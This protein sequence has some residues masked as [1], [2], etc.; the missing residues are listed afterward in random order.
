MTDKEV[1]VLVEKVFNVIKQSQTIDELKTKADK[2]NLPLYAHLKSER[3]PKI[4][5][6]ITKEE[7]QELCDNQ[8][9]DKNNLLTEDAPKKFDTVSKLL[10]ALVWKNGDLKKIKHIVQGVLDSHNDD[11]TKDDGLV[12]Y[13][14]GKYLSKT[15]GQPIIDQHVIRAFGVY[16]TKNTEQFCKLQ[17][18]NKTH[19]S[20]INEYK[21]WLISEEIPEGLKSNIEYSYYIDRLLFALG[22]TIKHK[23]PISS[24]VTSL[25]V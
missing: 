14:F 21:E 20:I 9:L 3:Y 5:F 16:K 10:Y 12:F 2:L 19:K 25:K 24:K 8:I 23:K 18:L 11:D 6:N 4:T 17:S 13:Q 15:K 7:I 1:I 22:K